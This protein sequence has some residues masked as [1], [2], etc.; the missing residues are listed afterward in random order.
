[1]CVLDRGQHMQIYHIG[2]MDEMSIADAAH[3]VA[4]YFG[5]T[6]EL[7]PGK[8]PEGGTR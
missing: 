7:L 8:S 5:Q 3:V 1:M 6:I 4:G 2:T